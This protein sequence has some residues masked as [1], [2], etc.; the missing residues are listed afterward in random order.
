MFKAIKK[1]ISWLA[2][3]TILVLIGL[4]V[5]GITT[6]YPDGQFKVNSTGKLSIFEEFKERELDIADRIDADMWKIQ[7]QELN[8]RL[9]NSNETLQWLEWFKA[10]KK[11]Y[12]TKPSEDELRNMIHS[13]M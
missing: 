6:Y 7:F 9:P 8:R 10:Y 3:H 13:F 5:S 11:T 4:L 12:G 2:E 1:I